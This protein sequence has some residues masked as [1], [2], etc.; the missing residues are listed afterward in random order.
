VLCEDLVVTVTAG[1]RTL[2][3]SWLEQILGVVRHLG[4]TD[5]LDQTLEAITQAVVEILQFR[6]AAINVVDPDGRMRVAAVAGP[7]ELGQLLGHTAAL[8]EWTDLLDACEP[9]GSL[10]FFSHERDQAV[11][12]RLANWTPDPIVRNGRDPDSWHPEDSLFAP[13][14]S[15]AGS[16]LGVLSVDQPHSGR[17][18]DLEQQTALEL[19]A[20]QAAQAIADTA[21]RARADARHREA[22]LRW[23]LTF[24]HSP[25]GAAILNT[26][27]RFLQLN[28]A[29]THMFGYS[30]A[31]LLQMTFL[32]LTHPDDVDLSLF[33]DIVAGRRDS[34]ESEK[35]YVHA[36]GQIVWGLV[37]VGIVRDD[38]G[39][40][41]CI[42]GQVSDITDRKLAEQ[43]LAHRATHD[44]LTNLANR[45]LLEER[46]ASWLSEGRPAGVLFC[47]L[48]RFKTINDS[49]GHDAGDEL[50]VAVARRLREVLPPEF[51]LGRVG[52]DEFVALAPGERDPEELRRLGMRLMSALKQPLPIR[53]HWH[54]VSVS[55][56]VTVS[57]PWHEHPDEVLRQADQALL[58]AK[59]HGRSRVE[60]YDPTQDKLATVEDLE[61]EQA[62]RGALGEGHGLVPFFQPI[63]NLDDNTPVGYEALIR[64]NHPQRGLLG[65]SEFLPLAEQ[66]GLVVAMG[67]WMLDVSCQAASRS[68]VNGSWPEWVAVNASGSQL[69][70]GQ[71]VPAICRALD[72]YDLPPE[73]LHLEITETAL[74]GATPAAIQ[75]VRD[76]ARLGVPIA[77]DDFGTGYSSLSLLRDLPVSAVKIDRSFVSPVAVDRRATAIVRSVIGLC[78]EL[79]VTTVAEGIETEEQMTWLRALGCTQAQGFL[80]GPPAPLAAD[81]AVSA[82]PR[83]RA[84][85]LADRT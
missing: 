38:T 56:G 70:R 32:D 36:S 17:R 80:I 6:A 54:T 14:V 76:V 3:R 50:L 77:L 31:Q 44:A 61:L 28:D 35:R 67:W 41:E 9:W 58:R 24:E 73:R 83:H 21:A 71:L 51:T 48:D 63:V 20:S 43:T 37:H 23:R 4:S 78:R 12:D 57:G 25:I 49:L 39:E 46:L 55:I 16:L 75:E 66:T 65:P 62:L 11:V 5:D 85:W 69:G 45:S 1:L 60:V 74:V 33:S 22:E 27:G 47:D 30:R 64:W 10:R 18:P 19:F 59:R 79:G 34:Y 40:V 2:R 8:R 68:A 52:G 42:I 53:G 7:A 26:D 81:V 29:L 82:V 13:L 84:S 72:A 15:S